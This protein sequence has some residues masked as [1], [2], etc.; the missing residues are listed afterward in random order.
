MNSILS[1]FRLINDLDCN[2]YFL[3]WLFIVI[4]ICFI[5]ALHNCL[6]FRINLWNFANGS[7]ESASCYDSPPVSFPYSP[8][9]A[10]CMAI[11]TN[12]GKRNSHFMNLLRFGMEVSQNRSTKTS[13]QGHGGGRKGE[14]VS[15]FLRTGKIDFCTAWAL[16]QNEAKM[17][18]I[19]GRA[20]SHVI[21]SQ[22]LPPTSLPPSGRKL[23]APKQT[24][25]PEPVPIPRKL[26]CGKGTTRK[27][28]LSALSFQETSPPAADKHTQNVETGQS[29]R[30]EYCALHP[31]HD[32]LDKFHFGN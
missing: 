10:K 19:K 7:Y 31:R 12:N 16:P 25:R 29:F 3:P 5:S 20:G 15:P 30:C 14:R 22:S 28:L 11:V 8:S 26:N 13:R 9:R 4:I 32:R 21:I 6:T 18:D 27:S 1:R 24:S 2:S 23:S 17:Y